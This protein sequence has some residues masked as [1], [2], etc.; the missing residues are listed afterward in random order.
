MKPQNYN[1]LIFDKSS[2]NIQW[3]KE[4]LFNKNCCE[5]MLAVC[6]KMKLDP[7]LS[8]YINMNSKWIKELNITPQTLSWYRKEKEILLN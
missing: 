7:C 1:Q 5:N 8:P 4:S 2:K 6:K 3:R